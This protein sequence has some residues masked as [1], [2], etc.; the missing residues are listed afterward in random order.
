MM[1]ENLLEAGAV[2]TPSGDGS[3]SPAVVGQRAARPAG[4]PDKF[5][6]EKNGQ[7]RLDTL[8]KSYLE[9][10][11]KLGSAG[12]DIPPGPDHYKVE[13]KSELLSPDPDVNRRL[14]PQDSARSKRSLST[15]WRATG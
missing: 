11:R 3:E 9:L 12:R 5:W 8:V 4:L 15:T 13:V 6:D 10:E 14:H 7:V 2:D 1:T